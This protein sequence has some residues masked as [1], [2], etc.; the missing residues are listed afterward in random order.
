MDRLKQK[1]LETWLHIDYYFI[2]NK[3][4]FTKKDYQIPDDLIVD[5]IRCLDYVTVMEKENANYAITVIALMWTHINKNRFDIR[6]AIIKFLS[7]IGYPTSAIMVDD[8]YDKSTNTFSSINSPLDKLT[9][10][11][12]QI[13]NE[14]T[15][16]NRQ[17]LL[18]SF[19]KRIWDSLDRN[20]IVGISAPT[21]A[22]KSFVILLKLI[23][24]IIANTCDIIYIIPT[25]S[26]LTQV[27]EDFNKMLKLLGIK[28]YS[29]SNSYTEFN[30]HEKSHIY[31]MT[32]EKAN[33]ALS[34]ERNAFNNRLILVADEIQNIER[35]LNYDDQRAKILFDTLTD[36]RYKENVEQIIIS[37]PRIQQID[38]VGENIFGIETDDVITDISPVLNLTYS[39]KKLEGQYY[40]KQYCLL[41]DS[42]ICETIAD[43]SLIVGYGKNKYDDNYFEYLNR[44]INCF[45]ESQN[46]VFAPTP[47]VARNIACNI[48]C[49]ESNFQTQELITYYKN[50]V[51]ENYS[52]CDSLS[53]GVAYHHGKLPMHVRCTLE[54]AISE[55]LIGTVAC[56]TTLMQG[57][58]MPAQNI[59][60][61]NPHL[62][63]SRR[64]STAELSNYEMANLRGR[65]GR[66]L[67]DFIG[68]TFVMDESSFEETDGYDQLNLFD[69]VEKELPSNYG[70]KFEDNKDQILDVLNSDYAVDTSMNQ[71]GFL[72]SHIRQSVLKFGEESKSRLENVGILLT[73]EQVAA[74]I[75]RM[76]KLSVP[77]EIC[78]KN[79]YWDPVVLDDIFLNYSEQV[80]AHPFEHGARAKL[81]RM[82][83]YLRDNE[84][85]SYMYDKHIVWSLRK[86][87][88]R[89]FLVSLCMKWSKGV[90]LPEILNNKKYDDPNEIDST[91]EVLQNTVSFQVPLLLKPIFDIKNPESSFLTC[92][93]S[94][95]FNL[96]TKRLIALGISRET[97]IYLTNNLFAGFN[98][99]Q[100]DEIQ[101]D[102]YIRIHLKQ[103]IESLP[104]WIRIQFEYLI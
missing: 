88:G 40:F 59:I 8:G 15:V 84:S 60:I 16:N 95:A 76:E 102:Q 22:G 54:K 70:Q 63:L 86:G 2:A 19:Q 44:I 31:I 64:S 12:N 6:S 93:Q 49:G 36:F 83:K 77:K 91:I 58:N 46:I 48:N 50:T 18:T 42:A 1:V 78:S 81:D 26:L 103:N 104:Y 82:L 94:G 66:L 25:L 65:A 89:S 7:R 41:T 67:K 34:S 52:M 33:S 39:I 92:M 55:R 79:R 9:I 47:D 85:T 71:Y 73:K 3:L 57:V 61:R 24:K 90:S 53:H 38:K 17:F 72:I 96:T 27:T 101:L 29:I 10:T 100:Y 80:P 30:E 98:A 11:L 20:K 37:G 21:S 87:S 74:I 14:V 56:T 35:I 43:S 23:S 99:E 45:G 4:G 13:P 51:R 68:R 62:Y 69:D 5:T 97:A 28:N 32:Q 75:L